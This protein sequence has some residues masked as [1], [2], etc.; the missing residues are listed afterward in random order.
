MKTIRILY[1]K[2]V[3]TLTLISSMSENLTLLTNLH[4]NKRKLTIVELNLKIFITVIL[5]FPHKRETS[6]ILKHYS[7]KIY[8][9]YS[10]I[11]CIVSTHMNS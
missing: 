7:Y 1:V 5:S 11:R 3:A 8:R 2:S 10:G 9:Y 4:I 6:A